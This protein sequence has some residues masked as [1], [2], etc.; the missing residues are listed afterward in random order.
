MS[1]SV[2]LQ[3]VVSMAL[4][5]CLMGVGFDTY[6]YFRDKARFPVWLTF[7]LDLFFWMASIGVI[8]Y[9]LVE[10]NQG[11]VRFPIFISVLVGAWLYFLLGSKT[12]IQFLIAVIKFCRWLYSTILLIIDI[13]LVRPFMFI[14]RLIYMIVAFILSVMLTIGGYLWRVI[15]WISSPFATWGQ[16]LGKSISSQIKGFWKQT[17]NWISNK[18]IKR[19]KP[20]E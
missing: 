15:L 8:F 12:Y 7:I 16:R 1:I 20:E 14:Y 11:I 4:C 18:W 10:V 3:T 13:L 9:V 6:Q 5:G 17:K 2:Q 19:K